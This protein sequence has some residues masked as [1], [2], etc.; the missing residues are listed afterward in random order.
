MNRAASLNVQLTGGSDACVKSL[1]P[2]DIRIRSCIK[3]KH[4]HE[5][6]RANGSKQGHAQSVCSW[7]THIEG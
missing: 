5:E 4:T 7:T 2:E 6:E 3:S 1:W